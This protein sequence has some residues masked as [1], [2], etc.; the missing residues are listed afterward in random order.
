MTVAGRLLRERC[1][2]FAGD[3]FGSSGMNV[4]QV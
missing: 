2:R 1:C 4:G 3:F